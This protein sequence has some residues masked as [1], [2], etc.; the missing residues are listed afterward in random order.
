MPAPEPSFELR[1]KTEPCRAILAHWQELRGNRLRPTRAEVDPTTLARSLP[2]AGLFEVQSLELTVCQLAGT[3]FHKSLGFELTGRNVIHIYAPS[4]H[5]AAGYRFLMMATHPC[6]AMF[7]MNLSFSIGTQNLHE[8]MLLPLG[9]N[10]LGVPPAL[11]VGIAAT[12]AVDWES[13]A[14]LPQASQSPNFRFF[15][16]GA[17]IPESWPP[18]DFNATA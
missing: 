5:R 11:L 6:A 7:D 17:G 8:V 12:G 10:A 3:A 15:D 13:T 9:P 4:L 2:H 14:M 1:P 18:D 16:I